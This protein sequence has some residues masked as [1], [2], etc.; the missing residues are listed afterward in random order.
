M[1]RFDLKPLANDPHTYVGHKIVNGKKRTIIIPVCV[2]DL[3]PI[4][5]EAL[6][7]EFENWIPDYFGDTLTGDATSCLGIRILRNQ[8]A[9][10][11]FLS[12]DQEVYANEIVRQVNRTRLS[13]PLHLSPCRRN[14]NLT[15]NRQPQAISSCISE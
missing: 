6:T 12:I 7:D 8:S 14:S 2:N 4:G 1:S 10:P 15:I 3:Y 11:P 5:D 9:N 13:H